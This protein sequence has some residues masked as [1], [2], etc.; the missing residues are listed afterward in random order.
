MV[1]PTWEEAAVGEG[2]H[3]L[4]LDP[5][6]AFGTAEHATTRGALRLLD[7]RLRA[8]DR[9]ADVGAGSGILSI[10]AALLGARCVLAVEM[11]P[12]ACQ[13]ARENAERNGVLDRIQIV[14][15]EV[16][17]EAL[18]GELPFDLIVANLES[19]TLRRLLVGLRR[20]A[21][22]EGWTLL[23]GVLLSEAD[24][25]VRAAKE[26]G[27]SLDDEDREEEWWTGAFRAV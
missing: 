11:D 12:W 13:V 19:A 6:M 1:S 10:A 16:G 17:P 5:G 21:T 26:S 9:V 25:I 3:L 24:A 22:V 23:G 8:G 27:F 7:P 14:Q 20:S 15:A 2:V 18:P 4:S